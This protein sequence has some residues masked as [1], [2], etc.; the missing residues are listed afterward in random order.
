MPPRNRDNEWARTRARTEFAGHGLDHGVVGRR[1]GGGALAIAASG[2]EDQAERVECSICGRIV[3]LRQAEQHLRDRH[4]VHPTEIWLTRDAIS[5]DVVMR[6]N[7]DIADFS[8]SRTA[9]PQ[10]E[11]I[12][13]DTRRAEDRALS[14]W[15][16]FKDQHLSPSTIES[17]F[18]V[19]G[20]GRCRSLVCALAAMQRRSLE[21]AASE[22]GG[23]RLVFVVRRLRAAYD[24]LGWVKSANITVPTSRRK[25]RTKNNRKENRA[26]K[27]RR[28]KQPKNT[29]KKTKNMKAKSLATRKSTKSAS[30]KRIK[31]SGDARKKRLPARNVRGKQGKRHSSR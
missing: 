8:H 9:V 5:P 7:L 23:E 20:I 6:I 27:I 1:D 16:S 15:H 29:R 3:S 28:G 4:R 12:G 14:A 24:I 13:P 25:P 30:G 26:S 2:Y 10:I 21:D 18:R 17:V 31:T 11:S 19:V 22:I